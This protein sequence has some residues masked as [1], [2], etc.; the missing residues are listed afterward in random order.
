MWSQVAIVAC[1]VILAVWLAQ[2]VLAGIPLLA[3]VLIL[4]FRKVWQARRD[5]AL[6]RAAS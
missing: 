4:R 3:F 2:L 1:W 6:I 5:H